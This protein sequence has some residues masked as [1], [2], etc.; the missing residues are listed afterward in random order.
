MMLFLGLLLAIPV[1]VI[2][3][4]ERPYAEREKRLSKRTRWD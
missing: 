1:G 3:C 2:M 4:M